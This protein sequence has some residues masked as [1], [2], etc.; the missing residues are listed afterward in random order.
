MNILELA[1]S[2]EDVC[3]Q[4]FKP[5][6]PLSPLLITSIIVSF[7]MTQSLPYENYCECY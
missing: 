5:P 2:E 4:N 6:T 7:R 1:I 3:D